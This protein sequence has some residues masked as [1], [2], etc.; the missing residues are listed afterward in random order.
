MS[1]HLYAGL[2]IIE[3][4]ACYNGKV[5]GIIRT[6]PSALC[7]ICMGKGAIEVTA[8]PSFIEEY[9]RKLRKDNDT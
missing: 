2:G 7:S 6:Y 4:H 3:A 9:N 1:R 8:Q 5:P